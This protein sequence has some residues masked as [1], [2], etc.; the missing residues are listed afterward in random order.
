MGKEHIADDVTSGRLSAE[1]TV[2]LLAGMMEGL[3]RD[4]AKPLTK[5]DTVTGP[6]QHKTN[7]SLRFGIVTA[8]GEMLY[9]EIGVF[10]G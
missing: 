1:D 4:V 5:L 6:L 9:V 7:G 8:R 10:H 3:L 2:S